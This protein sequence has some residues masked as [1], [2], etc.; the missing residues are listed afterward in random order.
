MSSLNDRIAIVIILL[1]FAAGILVW[2]LTR[3]K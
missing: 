2:K 3:R 1:M